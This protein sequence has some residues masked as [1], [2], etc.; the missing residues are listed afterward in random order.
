MPS[1]LRRMWPKYSSAGARSEMETG[2]AVAVPFG[3]ES[4]NAVSVARQIAS[5][6]FVPVI[7]GLPPSVRTKPA[8]AVYEGAC[9]LRPTRRSACL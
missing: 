3:D 9:S 5:A 1:G 4:A 6:I 8:H 7:S 2:P